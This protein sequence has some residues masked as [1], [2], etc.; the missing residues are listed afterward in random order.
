LITAQELIPFEKKSI[1]KTPLRLL[2][3]GNSKVW[4]NLTCFGLSKSKVC[5]KAG[6]RPSK[7]ILEVI[8]FNVD[9]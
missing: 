2:S 4:L 1:M 8:G 7:L 5:S 3:W 6:I 9:Q